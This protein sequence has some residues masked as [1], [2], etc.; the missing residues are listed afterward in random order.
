MGVGSYLTIPEI[1]DSEPLHSVSPGNDGHTF[2]VTMDVGNT[3]LQLMR[4]HEEGRMIPLVVLTT[5]A[6][7]P[8]PRC[9]QRHRGVHQRTRPGC[10]VRGVARRGDPICLTPR[11]EQLRR[12]GTDASARRWRRCGIDAAAV[13]AVIPAANACST[14]RRSLS[15]SSSAMSE[16]TATTSTSSGCRKVITAS[17]RS[18]T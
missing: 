13:N 12:R 6:Q 18:R 11:T 8:R 17:I 15:T 14:R 16:S 7:I 4:A 10:R 3:A 5:D 9:S 1:V 2:G